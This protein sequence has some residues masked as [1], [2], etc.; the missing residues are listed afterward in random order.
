MSDDA[1]KSPPRATTAAHLWAAT[2]LVTG[3]IEPIAA[4]IGFRA[5]ASVWEL[6]LARSTVAALVI[7]P[8]TRRLARLAG[9]DGARVVLAA[10]LLFT[11]TTLMLFALSRIHVADVIAILSITPATV[12]I[13]TWAR[14]RAPLGRRFVTGMLASIAGV[15]ITTGAFRGEVDDALGV[16][17]ALAAV[18]SSTTYRLALASLTSRT[19]PAVVSTWI[20]LIHGVIGLVLLGPF[21]GVPSHDAWVAGSWTGVAAAASN[22]AFVAAL[23][24]LGAPRASVV[25]LLQRPIIVVAAAL[26]LAES[27]GVEELIGIALVVAGVALSQPPR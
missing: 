26:V 2:A 19:D 25:M 14:T 15:A 23:A 4:K 20:Y 17:C 9:P 21:V 3:S 27:L 12:T 1:P 11:T 5:D 24:G 7:F 8:L 18:V 10:A 13:A 22:V 16:A 6:Q